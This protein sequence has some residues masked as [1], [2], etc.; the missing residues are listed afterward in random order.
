MRTPSRHSHSPF[1][2][3]AD[4]RRQDGRPAPRHGARPNSGF[5]MLELQVAMGVL[6]IG[7]LSLGSLMVRQSRQVERLEKWCVPDRTYHVVVQAN[8]WLRSLNAPADLTESPAQAPWQPPVST[9]RNNALTL[10]SCT[11]A[12]GIASLSAQVGVQAIV[13]QPKGKGKVK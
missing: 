12:V 4:R 1:P 3:S 13:V 8:S 7:L 10:L 6:A 5:T 11:R 9:Q 2:P